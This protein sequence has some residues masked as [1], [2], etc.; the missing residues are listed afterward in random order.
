MYKKTV[1]TKAFDTYNL[2]VILDA[3]AEL[4]LTKR[5][6]QHPADYEY[7]SGDIARAVVQFQSDIRRLKRD[8]ELKLAKFLL[9]S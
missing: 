8:M 2:N 9:K 1:N 5:A 6:E 7:F 4:I 3:Y